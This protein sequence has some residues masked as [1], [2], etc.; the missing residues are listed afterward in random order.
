MSPW[1]VSALPDLWSAEATDRPA[2]VAALRGSRMLGR[3]GGDDLSEVVGSGRVRQRERD[4]VLMRSGEDAV[5]ILLTGTAIERRLRPDG[6]TMVLRVLGPS[7][8]I[9]VTTALG[10]T[11]ASEVVTL[12]STTALVIPGPRLRGLARDRHEIALAWLQVTAEQLEDVR[13]DVLDLAGLSATERVVR[14]LVQ[15]V[16]RW[17]EVT[18]DGIQVQVQLTQAQ[19]ASWAG[20]SRE[21]TARALHMLRRSGVVETSRRSVVVRD[22]GEL[23]RRLGSLADGGVGGIIS[24]LE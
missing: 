23:R 10:H 24:A 12:V 21:S 16:E 15:L 13:S 3:L 14:R 4:S 5:M 9:G 11:D 20:T 17:G 18:Q 6:E 1:V 8:T 2:Y 19:L 22:M 7:D